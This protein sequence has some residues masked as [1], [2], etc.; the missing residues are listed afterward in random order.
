MNDDDCKKLKY[1]FDKYGSD[2]TKSSLVYIYFYIF[3]NFKINSLFEIGL[4]TNN[5]NLRSNMGIDGNQVLHYELL[6]II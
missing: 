4:G 6:E 2:K 1:L 3:K 5:V